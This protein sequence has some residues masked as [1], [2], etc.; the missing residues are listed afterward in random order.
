[1]TAAIMAWRASTKRLTRLGAL[2]SRVGRRT[3]G[4]FVVCALLPITLLAGWAYLEVRWSLLA[5][6]EERIGT[7]AK[8]HAVEIVGRALTV[9]EFFLAAR[10]TDRSTSQNLLKRVWLAPADTLRHVLTSQELA[11]V[12]AGGV[13]LFIEPDAPTRVLMTRI[14]DPG[15]EAARS[16]WAELDVSYLWGFSEGDVLTPG[17]CVIEHAS[18]RTLV[19]SSGVTHSEGLAAREAAFSDNTSTGTLLTAQRSVFFGYELGGSNW[20]V[21]TVLRRSDV[22]HVIRGFARTLALVAGLT[23][24]VVFFASHVQIRRTTAPLEQLHHA[25]QRMADGDFATSVAVASNDE[26]GALAR[27]FN[28]MSGALGR[29]FGA[30]QALD[31]V[32]RLALGTHDLAA[33]VETAQRR[34]A[35]RCRAL[36][37]VVAIP[38]AHRSSERW[39][40]FDHSVSDSPAHISREATPPT[41][42]LELEKNRAYSAPSCAELLFAMGVGDA[43]GFVWLMLPLWHSGSLEGLVAVG[44]PDRVPADSDDAVEA[45]RL[46]DRLAIAVANVRLVHQ[47]DALGLGTLTAFARAIDANSSWTAG[48]SERVT[49]MA[50]ALGTRAGLTGRD[51]ETLHRGGLLHDIGKIGVPASILDKPGRLTSE[52]FDV[53][54]SHPVLGHRILAPIAAFQ[55]VLPIVRSHHERMDGSGYPDGLNGEAIPTLARVLAVADV[56][57]ALVSDRPYRQ[58]MTPVQA[59]AEVRRGAG[60]HLDATLVRLFVELHAE[61]RMHREAGALREAAALADAV[62][63]GRAR[64]E[65]AA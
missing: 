12:R 63:A 5:E 53:V 64:I 36:R 55:D 42:L 65:V 34:V 40:V 30:L 9:R 56:Y 1:M 23:M 16:I 6:A 37:V 61:G 38:G 10:P 45:R 46:A 18:R 19:C 21:V 28:A 52:E 3:L 2:G 48:H 58:G 7:A 41:D 17:M 60:A 44:T 57:D 49:E 59:L 8:E 27:S 26:F 54:K 31:E 25:T 24:L 62:A 14:L 4:L 13:T 43:R 15:R 11:R 29:Q 35:E 51:L 32:D 50:I 22:L 33:V 39:S 47:L 20:H